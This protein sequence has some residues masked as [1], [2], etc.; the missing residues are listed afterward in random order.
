LQE[1]IGGSVRMVNARLSF[2]THRAARLRIGAQSL[3]LD[4][5]LAERLEAGRVIVAGQRGLPVPP[6]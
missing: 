2:V 5:K 1:G 3:G 4:S 6:F